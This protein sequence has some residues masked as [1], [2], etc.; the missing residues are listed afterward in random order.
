MSSHG[1]KQQLFEQFALIAKT[2]GHAHRLALVEH[3]AQGEQSVDVLAQKAGLSVANASQHLQQLRRAGLAATRRDGKFIFYRLADPSV[4]DLLTAL[5]Q[6]GERNLSE[7]Q[8]VLSGYFHDRDAMEAVTRKELLKRSRAG[9]VTIL[10]VRP[11]DEFA[12][13]HVAGAINI[14]M[15]DLERRMAELDPAIE[16][17]AYCRGPYCVFSFEAVSL[18]R[19]RGFHIRRLEDGLPE[20]QAAGL[21]VERV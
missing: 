8:V 14:P 20:W 9:A 11:H 12:L 13:A 21:P 1:P 15:G 4:L 17:V 3:L 5:H 18:L 19:K 6:I 16:I 7:V 10:D 2:L